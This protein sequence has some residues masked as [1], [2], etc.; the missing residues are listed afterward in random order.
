MTMPSTDE[1][2]TDNTPH[3]PPPPRKRRRRIIISDEEDD[4]EEITDLTGQPHSTRTTHPHQRTT[5]LATT[6]LTKNLALIIHRHKQDDINFTPP[7]LNAITPLTS[8]I[9][10]LPIATY[11]VTSLSAD[12]V[13]E[14][15]LRRQKHMITDIEA[16]THKASII[17]IQET[18]LNS[19]ATHTSLEAAFP[20]W[21]IFYNNPTNNKGGTLI[22]LSP[23]TRYNYNTYTVPISPD[24]Q[25]QAQCLRLEGR[26]RNG[27]T[28]LPFRLLNVYLATGDDHHRRRAKQLK[29]LDGI[30]NDIHLI[31]GGDYNFVEHEEDATNYSEYHT[32]K[33]GA[34]AAW[35]K[36]IHK[37]S[38]WETHQTTHT[39][40]S[41][42]TKDPGKSRTSRIDRF[43]I[44]HNEADATQVTAQASLHPVPHSATATLGGK[45]GQ[46]HTTHIPL[47]LT[48]SSPTQRPN[49]GIYR[50]PSWIPKTQEYKRI[51]RSMWSEH[52]P[53]PDTDI[54]TLNTRIKRTAKAAHKQFTR[55]HKDHIAYPLR[56]IDELTASIRLLHAVT[57]TP[58]NHTNVETFLTLNPYLREH[59]PPG[60]DST[61]YDIGAL[62][63]H[64]S[65]LLTRGEPQPALA[66]HHREDDDRLP[67]SG[68]PEP[69]AG[70]PPITSHP[71]CPPPPKIS[72][73][74]AP[75]P[76]THPPPAQNNKLRWQKTFGGG[77]FGAK[78]KMPL[79]LNPV[80][81]TSKIT[82]KRSPTTL[83][84]TSRQSIPSSTFSKNPNQPRPAP[85]ASPFHYTV[86]SATSPPLSSTV[87]FASWR[88]AT[89]PPNRLTWATSACSPRTT[90][91]SYHAHAPSP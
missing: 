1:Q 79:T 57:H 43:Y 91:H 65:S 32:L 56:H 64:I 19:T 63:N 23:H 49:E 22:M 68:T 28:P 7:S 15:G 40:I 6:T 58:I 5:H 66:Q 14:I 70:A 11:N 73:H 30:P 31:T 50:L 20:L 35:N 9:P 47:L 2:S 67:S 17:F 83:N 86:N 41:P 72:T 69:K 34:D 52:P 13:D 84:P 82:T 21:R 80:P 48:F 87:S 38:L 4:D 24:L 10:S 60:H 29:L 76:L 39:N 53:P 12:V 81:T 44:T 25:G 33:K 51:F 77:K 89:P 27:N 61:I 42:N 59:L 62:R 8:M 36:F 78:G 54:F 71:S 18:R 85:M 46:R 3:P 55:A 16:L 37:H 74:Y 75:N 90:P 26:T 88:K 45:Q